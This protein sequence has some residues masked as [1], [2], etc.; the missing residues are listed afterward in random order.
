MWT[1]PQ[2]GK[3]NL[4]H[5][6]NCWVM[7][8]EAH[9]HW[10]P[11]PP[12]GPLC[13]QCW[14]HVGPTY[15]QNGCW[16]LLLLQL[17]HMQQSQ[18]SLSPVRKEC[19]SSN[20]VPCQHRED[21]HQWPTDMTFFHRMPTLSQPL[22][23]LYVVSDSLESAHP[24]PAKNKLCIVHNFIYNVSYAWLCAIFH[25]WLAFLC[26]S[27]YCSSSNTMYRYQGNRLWQVNESSHSV[28]HQHRWVGGLWL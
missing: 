5:W 20:L 19:L 10:V 26:Q 1:S 3:C 11:H 12:L 27:S 28:S 18:L 24:V 8:H 16:S 7:T 9:T 15:G 17:G 25:W 4:D 2:S 13:W 22:P 14:S 23:L 6:Q 21:T